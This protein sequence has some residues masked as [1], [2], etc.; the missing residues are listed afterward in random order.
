MVYMQTYGF[1]LT[2][3]IV[4][5]IVAGGFALK[6]AIGSE[7]SRSMVWVVLM[8]I[9]GV[10]GARL[11]HVALH[12]ALYS[13]SP[14]L[15]FGFSFY[16]FTIIGGLAGA[17]FMAIVICMFMGTSTWRVADAFVPVLGIAIVLSRIGC[18]F[19]G[20]CFGSVTDAPWAMTFPFG[21]PAYNYTV[22]VH[23]KP[24]SSPFAWFNLPCV[25]PTMLYEAGGV[26]FILAIVMRHDYL[27][28]FEGGRVL[29]FIGGYAV[30]RFANHWLRIV[31]TTFS[32]A[33]WLLPGVYVVVLIGAVTLFL[34]KKGDFDHGI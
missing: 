18:Y 20:C 13:K 16:G 7:A 29:M 4:W 31:P 2:M 6:R 21:T 14:S 8:V 5:S 22:A 23:I 11:L 27:K 26:L 32:A 3:A 34:I 30:L 24:D 19:N 17:S 10:V 12:W 1:W 25:H 15:I 33:S 28:R 9:G